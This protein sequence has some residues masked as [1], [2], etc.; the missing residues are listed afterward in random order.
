MY[1]KPVLVTGATGYV[2]G[3]L[4]PMLLVQCWKVRAMGRS[5]PKLKARRWANHP[6]AELVQADAHDLESLTKAAE[7]CSVA[8]YLI[9]SLS[10]KEADFAEADRRAARNMAIAAEKAGLERIIYLGGLT[11]SDPA[12]SPH[13]RSRA[14]VAEILQSGPVPVTWLRA[15]QILGSGSAAFELIR[16]VVDRLPIIPAP[17][18]IRTECQPISIR[19]VLGYLTGCLE[20]PETIGESYDIGGPFIESYYRLLRIYE[21]E[22]GLRP[23]LI[24][25]LPFFSRQFSAWWVGLLTPISP[26]LAGPLI[27]GMRNRVVCR[28]FRIR[29]IIPQELLGCRGAIRRALEKIRMQTVGTCW[30]DA[31]ELCAPEWAEEGDAPY[32]GGDVLQ[33]G[34]RIELEAPP[35]EVWSHIVSIGGKGGWY[36]GNILWRM[37]GLLDTLSGGVGMRRGR[38]HPNVLGVGEVLDFWRVLD[39]REEERLFLLAEMKLPGE[40]LLEFRLTPTE[41]GGTELVQ[42][43]RFLPRGL[44]GLLYWYATWPLHKYIFRGMLHA[45]ARRTGHPASNP[46]PL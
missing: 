36:C 46:E 40:A 34:Y 22:A 10:P 19:N 37:R 35:A 15:A 3:R 7:G 21:E 23:R 13:L 33:L 26:S 8:F 27:D 1:D 31:G 29:K 16:Y 20:K 14:E 39:M 32:S 44:F 18:W 45:V 11:P 6:N 25:P 17:R 30:S 41:Q 24:I 28:E 12:L 42:R 38:R 2:G 4:A 5:L 43:S 9:H